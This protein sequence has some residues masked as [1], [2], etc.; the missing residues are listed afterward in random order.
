[1]WVRFLVG[2][3]AMVLGA[4]CHDDPPLVGVQGRLRLSSE[5]VAFPRTYVGVTRQETVRVFNAGRA[6]LTVTW[7]Q[8]DAPFTIEG[9]PSRVSRDEVEYLHAKN[10]NITDCNFWSR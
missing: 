9:L 1:M 10:I 4:G 7:T 8:V 2:L 3:M 5:A 6:P